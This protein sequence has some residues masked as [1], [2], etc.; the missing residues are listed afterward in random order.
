[1]IHLGSLFIRLENLFFAFL[2]LGVTNAVMILVRNSTMNHILVPF[3]DRFL[4]NLQKVLCI[5]DE[6]IVGVCFNV[7]PKNCFQN[8]TFFHTHIQPI[9]LI[10]KGIG[11]FLSERCSCHDQNVREISIDIV[12]RMLL[13]RN[14]EPQESN[15]NHAA[16]LKT[17]GTSL[18]SRSAFLGNQIVCRGVVI[19]PN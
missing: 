18:H 8:N 7:L 9:R 10:T 11:F 13:E 16:R 15:V 4:D 6:V 2:D 1:M 12:V 19:E 5:I 3:E 14:N 17:P